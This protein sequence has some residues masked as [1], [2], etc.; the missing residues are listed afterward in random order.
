M[1]KVETDVYYYGLSITLKN[2][3]SFPVAIV[4][5]MKIL[6]LHGFLRLKLSFHEVVDYADMIILIL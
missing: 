5:H 3:H 2:I 6:Q 4:S 1:L